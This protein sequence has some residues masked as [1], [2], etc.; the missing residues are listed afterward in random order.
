MSELPFTCPVCRGSGIV[1]RPPWV[2]GDVASWPEASAGTV[3]TCRA[4]KGRGIVWKDKR[5]YDAYAEEEV[6]KVRELQETDSP[7]S[8]PLPPVRPGILLRK[9]H[10]ELLAE[11]TA[12]LA[13]ARTTQNLQQYAHHTWPCHEKMARLNCSCTCGYYT[14][15]MKT[16]EALA[17][18]NVQRLMGGRCPE[19]GGGGR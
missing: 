9:R 11:H 1:S 4:C 19:K 5:A 18:L 13:V 7:Q 15:N 16:N 12:L 10:S 3:Y 2:A 8:V 17:H 6:A 14:A